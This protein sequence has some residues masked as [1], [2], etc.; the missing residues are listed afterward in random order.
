MLRKTLEAGELCDVAIDPRE[1]EAELFEFDVRSEALDVSM[2]FPGI[3]D[4]LLAFELLGQQRL[5][6]L[7]LQVGPDEHYVRFR[8]L[9]HE[10]IVTPARRPEDRQSEADCTVALKVVRGVAKIERLDR[11]NSIR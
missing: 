11:E 10:A 4:H 6:L 7:H 9:G 8:F 5:G 2:T 1:E 3:D